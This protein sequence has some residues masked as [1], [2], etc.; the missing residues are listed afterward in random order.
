MWPVSMTFGVDAAKV[1]E[2]RAE[3]DDVNDIR[4]Y[5]VDELVKGRGANAEAL[6]WKFRFYRWAVGILTAETAVLIIALIL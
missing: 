3:G 1:L 6:A 2:R 4:L 5:V